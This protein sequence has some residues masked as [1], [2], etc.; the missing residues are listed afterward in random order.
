MNL[1]QQKYLI[2]FF[3]A[4]M[5]AL[6]ITTFLLFEKEWYAYLFI[7]IMSSALNT[8]S[9]ILIFLY[10]ML[11]IHIN[12][13]NNTIHNTINNNTYRSIPKNYLY[14]IPCYNESEEELINSLQSLIEQRI[15][16]NDKRLI[17]IICDGKV[18]GLGNSLSTDE[19]LKNI[20]SINDDADIYD[21]TTWSGSTNK[22]H[23][24]IC[25]YRYNNE[26]V[27]IIL[28]IKEQNIGKRD[29]LVIARKL[30]YL[31]NTT[32]ISND[33]DY[34]FFEH[35]KRELKHICA[36]TICADTICA[37]TIC[38]DNICNDKLDYIIGIDADTI[39]DYNCTYELIQGIEQDKNIHGCVGLI[40][41][42]PKMNKYSF[43]VLYQY[44]EYIYSQ[45]LKRH[46][47]STI[48]HKVSC[49]SGCN[50]ILRVSEETC[51]E[52]ILSVFNYYPKKED[53]ILTHIRSYASEDR[54][55]VCNM[56]SLYPYVKTTQNLKAISYTIVPSSV[57]VFLSQ[58]R[59]WNL[60]AQSNDILLTYSPGINI[61]ERVLACVNIFTFSL[62]PFI[63]IATIYFIKSII[64]NPSMLMLYLS[65]FL[66]IPLLY[67][68]CIPIFIKPESFATS[69]YYYMSYLL[70]LSCSGVIN[71]TSFLYSV[72]QMDVITWGK[73]RSIIT[74]ETKAL[75]AVAAVADVADV[76]A[77]AAVA[78]VADAVNITLETDTDVDT[79]TPTDNKIMKDTYIELEYDYNYLDIC[80][81]DNL[82][83]VLNEC[84][85]K[86]TNTKFNKIEE[87]EE[88]EEKD[89]T[90]KNNIICIDI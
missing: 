35:M 42:N 33:N 52:K 72:L 66:L 15:V 7:L 28:L 63:F 9:S 46:A 65:I 89:K 68:L 23:Q 83:S 32:A 49:L 77:V 39:F 54:N 13:N 37:D 6:L 86:N 74:D 82:Y 47:Q 69:M 38:A 81:Q 31:Y 40:D 24:Y 48:T 19:I 25:D 53:N 14:V 5:N 70:F 26:T 18:K 2:N 75:A 41:I 17:L 79:D 44:A 12:I 36:D 55:H 34:D 21:Y 10:K 76:A 87:E 73:T 90:Y 88:E 61:F 8:S 27:P 57:R 67:S 78:D 22:I 30:C 43:Y 3:I 84:I 64:T 71:L 80:K 20:L 29:S 60:G 45:C 4:S 58:R 11:N 56:L 16:K 51:G 62:A 85:V 1:R 59:R 50:Q